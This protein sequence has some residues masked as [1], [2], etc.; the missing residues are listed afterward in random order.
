M[1]TLRLLI[2]CLTCG[3][4][5]ACIG[6]APDTQSFGEVTNLQA[7]VEEVFSSGQP[8]EAQ[9]RRMAASGVKHVIN[10]RPAT[11]QP[12]FN[13]GELIRSLGMSYHNIPV[14]GAIDVT[15]E[16]AAT[17]DDLLNTLEGPVLVHCASGNR[18][19]ALR[20]VTAAENGA[21]VDQALTEG[22][23]WGLTGMT[24]AVR[25]ILSR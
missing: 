9:F 8:T 20:A 11:E 7:P 14:S 23:R 22:A 13:E 19:G 12:D 5:L 3:A 6:T 15:G 16:N 18:V 4:L 2:L 1:T 17:L 25:E 10:L 21:S 24:P